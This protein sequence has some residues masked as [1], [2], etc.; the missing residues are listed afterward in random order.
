MTANIA[1]L[2]EARA[3]RAMRKNALSIGSVAVIETIG[4]GIKR[5]N[6]AVGSDCGEQRKHNKRH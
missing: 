4:A 2:L 6:I 1:I 3:L 5:F